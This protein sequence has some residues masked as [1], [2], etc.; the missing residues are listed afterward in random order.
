MIKV[1]LKINICPIIRYGGSISQSALIALPFVLACV[2][3]LDRMVPSDNLE[4]VTSRRLKNSKTE[5]VR[6]SSLEKETA[7]RVAH[8]TRLQ[9]NCNFSRRQIRYR[10]PL[11][12]LIQLCTSISSSLYDLYPPSSKHKKRN[13][14]KH[15]T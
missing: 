15:S 1:C 3:C 14:A 9:L 12:Y 6:N 10:R 4:I 2:S 13:R 5:Q 11:I 8:W 7:E